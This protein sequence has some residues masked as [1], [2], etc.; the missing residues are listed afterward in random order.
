MTDLMASTA[1][2][3]RHRA[4]QYRALADTADSNGIAEELCALAADYER[5]A[6]RLEARLARANAAVRFDLN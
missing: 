5:D 3:L 4:S 2:H 1:R 6:A